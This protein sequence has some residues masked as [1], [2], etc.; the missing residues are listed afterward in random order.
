MSAIRSVYRKES[1][2]MGRLIDTDV[3]V[4]VMDKHTKDD[5]TLDDDITCILEE[6]PTAYD[7]EAVVAELEKEKRKYEYLYKKGTGD[8]VMQY[9]LG[10]CDGVRK[11]ISIVRGKE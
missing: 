1:D 7:V 9:D 6:V 2:T 11:A 10:R 3:L 4:K 5:D 8:S